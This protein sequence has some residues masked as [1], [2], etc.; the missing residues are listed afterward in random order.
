MAS[1]LE[2]AASTLLI[3]M[4]FT[5]AHLNRSEC[6]LNSV[7]PFAMTLE[8]PQGSQPCRLAESLAHTSAPGVCVW[9]VVCL[10]SGHTFWDT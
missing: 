2:C 7:S 5:V 8:S 10:S 4:T 6:F 9:G 1:S 3:T